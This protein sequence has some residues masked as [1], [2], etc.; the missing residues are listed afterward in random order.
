[1]AV[2]EQQLLKLHHSQT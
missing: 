1:M 2:L